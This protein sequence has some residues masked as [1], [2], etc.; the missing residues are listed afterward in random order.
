MALRLPALK[1]SYSFNAS[2]SGEH[3]N[4]F[5]VLPYSAI[6]CSVMIMMMTP[7]IGFVLTTVECC[8]GQLLVSVNGRLLLEHVHV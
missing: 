3:L 4:Y 5:T 2:V 1:T 6:C 7:L 8:T